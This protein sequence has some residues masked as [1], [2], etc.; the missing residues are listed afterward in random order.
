MWYHP[1]NQGLNS[2]YGLAHA[3]ERD[4]DFHESNSNFEPP[5][6]CRQFSPQLVQHVSYQQHYFMHHTSQQNLQHPNQQNL[7]QHCLQER[8]AHYQGWEVPSL[9]FR[10]LSAPM[11]VRQES[12]TRQKDSSQ[13]EQKKRGQKGL[14]PFVSPYQLIPFSEGLADMHQQLKMT[15]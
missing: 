12:A 15:P 7:H 5:I 13:R 4:R 2:H 9:N 10:Q 3:S 11:P 8:H 6:L 14:P 1:Q